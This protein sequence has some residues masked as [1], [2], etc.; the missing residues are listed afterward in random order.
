MY[1][2][3]FSCRNKVAVVT[4]GCGLIGKEIVNALSDFG[5][6]VYA[7]D[8]DDK[9]AAGLPRKSNIKYIYLDIGSEDSVKKA[10][11]GVTRKSG[12]I[13]ILVNSAYPKT[14]DWN[15]RFEKVPFD[16]WKENVNSHLGGYFLCCR[17]AAEIMKKRKKG[18]IINLSSIYGIRAP[19]FR[20]YE[21]TKMTMPVAYSAIKSGIIALTKY[22]SSY[23]G[24]YNIR[25]NAVSPGGIFD[26]QN[27]HFVRKYIKK[28]SLVR[29]GKP[30][31]VAGAVVYLASEASSYV[32]GCNLVVD[33]GW[34]AC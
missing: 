14:P 4:G 19:D 16:S 13:D 6:I 28:T 32:T 33:G 7:A 11:E 2:K 15:T 25:A 26:N 22:L 18:S 29:M 9:K 17:S 20:I 31:D 23:Y 8:I 34:T 30:S 3:L 24:K 1:K 21:G 12:R 5:A 10:M 27:P